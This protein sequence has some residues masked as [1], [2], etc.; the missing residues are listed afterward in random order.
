MRGLRGQERVRPV[1]R[2]RSQ[3]EWQGPGWLAGGW[4]PA[5]AGEGGTSRNLEFAGEF[6]PRKQEIREVGEGTR[7]GYGSAPARCLV[8]S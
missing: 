4:S 3:T 1:F 8:P 5:E 2:G 6:E 7:V